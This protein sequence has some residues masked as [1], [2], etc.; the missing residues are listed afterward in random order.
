MSNA[1]R[2]IGEMLLASHRSRF[3]ISQA[4]DG[5]TWAPN[6]QSTI[7]AYVRA[8]SG[9]RGGN[10]QRGGKASV[11]RATKKVLVWN[12]VLL[13]TIGYQVT[14]HQLVFGPSPLTKNYAAV[15]Q[16]GYAPRNIPA[17]PYLGLTAND[18]LSAAA[19]IAKH[20][21]QNISDAQS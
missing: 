18:K 1:F 19:I 6:K 3:T 21:R 4:P 14:P 8:M 5:S 9:S 17:R 7:D 2:E 13:R 10:R 15:Q 12:N 11:A 20:I 16:F